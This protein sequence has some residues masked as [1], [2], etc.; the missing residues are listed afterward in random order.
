MGKNKSVLIMKRSKTTTKDW[1]RLVDK[2]DKKIKSLFT[3]WKNDDATMVG[4][5]RILMIQEIEWSIKQKGEFY[6]GQYDELL[7]SVYEKYS[8][9]YDK[10]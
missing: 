9:D 1:T 10:I 2:S 3:K 5:V 6:Y 8:Q 7:K 4:L